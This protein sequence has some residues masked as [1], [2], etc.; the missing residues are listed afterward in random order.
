MNA[1][2][3]DKYSNNSNNVQGIITTEMPGKGTAVSVMRF[4]LPLILRT[5]T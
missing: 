2:V 1:E 5:V 4:Y 3:I